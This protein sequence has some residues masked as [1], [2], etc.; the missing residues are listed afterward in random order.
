MFLYSSNM[1]YF[2]TYRFHIHPDSEDSSPAFIYRR[3]PQ[4]AHWLGQ[5]HSNRGAFEEQF[6]IESEEALNQLLEM[7]DP[8][9]NSAVEMKRIVNLKRKILQQM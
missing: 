4:G 8:Y 1:A 2:L 5:E 7:L 9:F 3:F 6:E